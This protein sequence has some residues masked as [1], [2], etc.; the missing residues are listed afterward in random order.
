MLLL[1]RAIQINIR[2]DPNT[3]STT[4]VRII[5]NNA[6]RFRGKH[7]PSSKHADRERDRQT[8][9][10]RQTERQTDRQTDRKTDRQT[11]RHREMERERGR[12]SHLVSMRFTELLEAIITHRR[13][14]IV[15]KGVCY[16]CVKTVLRLT[17]PDVK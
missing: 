3:D 5:C 12:E 9:R 17:K 10:E 1:G 14:Q 11:D 2:S 15:V 8:E 7:F 6:A 13:L 16:F 4:Q